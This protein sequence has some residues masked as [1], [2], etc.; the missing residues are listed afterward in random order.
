MKQNKLYVLFLLLAL[1]PVLVR[2]QQ[3]E[4]NWGNNWV[5]PG[6]QKFVGMDF[7]NFSTGVV[8]NNATVWYSGNFTNDGRVDFDN[9][10]GVNPGQTMFAGDTL[11]H[12]AGSGTTRFYSLLFGSQLTPIAYNLEQNISVVHL[13]N[14]TKGILTTRQTTPETMMNML[15]LEN[16][17]VCINA[18]ANSYVDGF[19]SKTGNSTFTFPI[20]NGGFYRPAAI[21][22]PA[23]VTDCFAARYLYTNPDNAGYTRT[24]KVADLT[25]ISDKEYW[26]VN[27]TIGTTVTNGELTLSWNVN[28]T[29]APVPANLNT[30]TVARWDGVKWINEGNT[31]TTGDATAG[32]ITAK[33]SGYGIFTLATMIVKPPVVVNDSINTLEDSPLTGAVLANDSVFYGGKPSLIS[34]SIGGINYQPGSTITIPNAGTV[35]IGADGVFTYSPV[36]NYNGV[37]PTITYIIIDNNSNTASGKLIINVL[38]LPEFIKTSSKPAMNNDGSF[39]WIYTLTLHND[40]NDSIRNIQVEDN[41][42][43][44]FSSKGC[45]YSVTQILASGGLTANGLYNGSGNVKTL[46]DGLTMRAGQLDSIS[47]EVNVNT[48][49]QSDTI[50]VFNQANLTAKAIFGDFS[51]KS[52][53]DKTSML[54]VYTQTKIP[55]IN[56]IITDGF[57]PNGDGVNDQFVITHEASTRLDIEIADRIGNVVYKSSDYQNDWDGK[58][59]NGLYGGSDLPTGTYFVTY[60]AIKI[61]SGEVVAKG[62]KFITLRRNT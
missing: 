51:L 4:Y 37:L 58:S 28:Q 36:L 47:I 13:L 23:A 52:H 59:M 1:L 12:I 48:Q 14:L 5:H 10:L 9:S 50:L 18:S 3:A 43:D 8:M 33:V 44:V 38:P 55:V 25:S 30:L 22:A 62:L 24:K 45:T 27:H 46:I 32:T 49:G 31:S 6:G 7:I 19:V 11:Q 40:T 29:S 35:T 60:K 34:F 41:L 2:G 61:S 39:S 57:S 56:V 54:A 16:G 21:S 26:V 17:A 20:G 42:D 53:A 15:Q